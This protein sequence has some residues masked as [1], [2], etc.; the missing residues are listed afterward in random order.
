MELK[1]ERL[2]LRELDIEDLAEVVRLADNLE[3]SKYLEKV[4]HPY[5]KK[6]G[7]WFIGKC[8]NDAKKDPR[9]NYELAIECDGKLVGLIGLTDVNEF[10]GTATLGYWLGE[11]YWRQGIMSEASREM[12]RFGF[13]DLGLRRIDIEA[14]VENEGSNALIKKLGAESEGIR[15]QYRKSISTGAIADRNIYGLL[16]NNWENDKA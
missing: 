8:N 12:V 4:P 9:E 1:T 16:R 7:E 11:E 2:V 3:V 14:D 13:E 10:H 5:S 6:D 15:K